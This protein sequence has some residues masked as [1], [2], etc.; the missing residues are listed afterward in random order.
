VG[1]YGNTIRRLRQVTT[2]TVDQEPKWRKRGPR[3]TTGA[4]RT[5]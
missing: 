2:H 4:T 3:L 1:L 5:W